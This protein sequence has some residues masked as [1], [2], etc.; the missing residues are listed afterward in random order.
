VISS[1]QSSLTNGNHIILNKG[2]RQ[3][4]I[5]EKA[6]DSIITEYGNIK[7]QPN[8]AL[9]TDKTGQSEVAILCHTCDGHGRLAVE[10][11]Q[12]QDQ[13]QA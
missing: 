7:E 10:Q 3:T 5:L 11:K 13:R 6:F 1:E 4:L 12:D 9:E 2:V 8:A